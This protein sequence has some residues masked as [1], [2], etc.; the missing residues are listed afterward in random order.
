M[1]YLCAIRGTPAIDEVVGISKEPQAERLFD[2]RLFVCMSV[3]VMAGG[4]SFQEIP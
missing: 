4:S 3:K 2:I 1:P